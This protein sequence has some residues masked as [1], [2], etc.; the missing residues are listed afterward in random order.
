VKVRRSQTQ[1]KSREE[2]FK[3]RTD[4][5]YGTGVGL[6]A[7]IKANSNRKTI[8]SNGK[9]KEK[10]ECKCGSTS[11]SRTTH[12]DCPLNKKRKLNKTDNSDNETQDIVNLP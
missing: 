11:H 8:V 5:S 7:G 2:V 3:E 9:N 4:N 12:T 1:K 10:G 6:T